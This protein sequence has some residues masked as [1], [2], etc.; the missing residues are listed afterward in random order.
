MISFWVTII[1]LLLIT[2][3]VNLYNKSKRGYSIASVK[4]II[5][6]NYN[7]L[8]ILIAIVILSS[9]Q[10]LIVGQENYLHSA[11]EDFFDA[12]NGGKNYFTNVPLK[13]MEEDF[14]SNFPL[15]YSS[16]T[17]W[18]MFLR[19]DWVDGFLQQSILNLFLTAIGVFWLTKYV[20]NTKHYIALLASFWS[21]ASNFYLTTYLNGHIGS[22]MYGSVI[23]YFVGIIL[24]WSQN[25]LG[26][27]WLIFLIFLFLWIHI[28]Y[29]GPIYFVLIPAL[30]IVIYEKII[31]PLEFDKKFLKFLKNQSKNSINGPRFRVNI[32]RV[33]ILSGIILLVVMSIAL[34]SYNYFEPRRISAILRTNVSW[35]ISLFKE[36]LMV[37]WG[38]YPSGSSGTLSL[39]P[40]LISNGTI[41]ALSLLGA[42]IVTCIS[43]IAAI[44]NYHIRNRSY[45]LVYSIL[46]IPFFIIMR[47]FWGSPY[48]FYKFLYTNYFLIVIIVIIWL[49]ENNKSYRVWK[50]NPIIY[51]FSLVGLLNIAWDISISY[52]FYRRIYNQKNV[53]SDFVTHLSG[54]EY[55]GKIRLDIPSDLYSKAFR[56]IFN[57]NGIGI[58]Q[59]RTQGEFVVQV[60][61]IGDVSYN[62]VDKDTIIYSNDLLKLIKPN[63]C[64]RMSI[65]TQYPPE[66]N[67]SVNIHW[68]GNQLSLQRGVITNSVLEVANQINKMDI[69]GKIFVDIFTDDIQDYTFYIVDNIFVNERIKA[70][71]DP[72]GADYFLRVRGDKTNFK[73][74]IQNNKEERII[75]QNDFFEI[76][77][78]PKDKRTLAHDIVMNMNVST[79]VSK[80][81]E[82]GNTIYVDTPREDDVLQLFFKQRVVPHGI[83]IVNDPD[84][85]MLFCRY[86]F[87]SP[88]TSLSNYTITSSKE[89]LIYR[90][91]N[92]IDKNFPVDFELIQIPLKGRD[93][94]K[95]DGKSF[96]RDR[97]LL[98]K[99]KEDFKVVIDNPSEAV[100]FIRMLIAPGPSIDFKGFNLIVTSNDSSF[101]KTYLIQSPVTKIDIPINQFTLDTQ[102]QIRINLE[103][104]DFSGKNLTGHSLL[105][106]EERYLLYNVLAMELTDNINS[107]SSNILR[108]LNSQPQPRFNPIIKKLFNLKKTEDI[109]ETS[110]TNKVF[111]GLGWYNP[112]KYK[113]ELFRWV[114]K[115]TAEIIL[116]HFKPK[117]NSLILNLE[118]GPGTTGSPLELN[119]LYNGNIFQQFKVEGKRNVEISFP[120]ETFK[121]SP[122]QII[123]KLITNSQDHKIA[124]DPRILNYRVNN[125][126]LKQIELKK[127]D[128]VEAINRDEIQVGAGWYTYE[129][130]NNESFRWVGR[131]PA[132]IMISNP[133]TT[134]HK[135]KLDIEPGPGCA[136]KPLRIKMFF[137][138]R[139]IGEKTAVGRESLIIDLPERSRKYKPVVLKLLPVSK[140]LA[141]KSDKR[142]LNFRTFNISL[143]K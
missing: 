119:V 68:V 138:N 123:L 4:A 124:S 61:N 23:P 72:N 18:H 139:F 69:G 76:V 116:N 59:D 112:D 15:Q 10:Y 7:L 1:S 35:K 27:K 19:N 125:I 54:K 8:F 50:I 63:I 13:L 133:D 66:Y 110:D 131:E 101:N 120:R 12:I 91:T 52:D 39:L 64:N 84:S 65:E 58:V 86:K 75:W 6:E 25:K 107:Y 45:L 5:K 47:Y 135:I 122:D 83:R 93:T 113:G 126:S 136:G 109:I 104:K 55:E 114:G 14:R 78:I 106:I 117:E 3:T 22:L 32:L 137:D 36:M 103:G 37:F 49:C 60:K 111:F 2:I 51:L 16:Q 94:L 81:K 140:N 38:I 67:G 115:D 90:T 21:V 108:I 79:L 127:N 41:N 130:Y 34:W 70:Q 26:K 100:K 129:T 95:R 87:Y 132:E 46:F 105:P 80:I 121:N 74:I 57:K 28:T 29:P 97:F 118:P 20:F 92:N 88:L 43:I 48:Y 85:T 17:F 9:W 73:S 99:R 134:F 128:I 31:L 62:T 44:T 56:Y 71:K 77:L 11:N 102:T 96:F 42:I 40:L 53:I 82:I 89:K 30:I 142:I 24:L 33:L 141:I 98:G 143:L